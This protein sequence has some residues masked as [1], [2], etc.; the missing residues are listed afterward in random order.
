VIA[1]EDR[2]IVPPARIRRGAARRSG[3]WS[4]TS[5]WI[6]VA[7]CRSSTTQP[8]RTARGPRYPTS[9]AAMRSRMGRRRLPPAPAMNSPISWISATGE[10][11]S[12]AIAS[13]TALSSGPTARATRS[14]SS[15]SSGVGAFTAGARGGGSTDDDA[16]FHLDLRSGGEILDLDD[17]ELVADLADLS[18]RHLL[19]Q[20]AQQ[21]A[22]DGMH[23]G[24]LVAAH[25]HD[26]ARP[27]P[28]VAREVDDEPRGVH[29]DDV[30][31]GE[32][33]GLGPAA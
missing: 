26:A 3:A 33:R 23:D 15:A 17:R 10:S 4:T 30:A 12:P 14:F 7:V 32:R 25:A 21:F 28:V 9:R 16:V 6:R 31:A 19:V 18:R 24:D 1:H 11:I 2:R 22:R 20:L 27:D 13:S 8:I 5:S 29:V